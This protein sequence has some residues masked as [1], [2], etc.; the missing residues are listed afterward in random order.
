[1]PCGGRDALMA[2]RFDPTD[3]LGMA[4]VVDGQFVMVTGT[5]YDRSVGNDFLEA[6]KL[7]LI[8]TGKV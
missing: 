5:Y 2:I 7:V 4:A 6:M 1:M 3:Q 8:Q